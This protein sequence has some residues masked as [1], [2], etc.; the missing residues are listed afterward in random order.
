M[1]LL[2]GGTGFI[3]SHLL[4]ELLQAG[5]EVVAV[6]RPGSTPVIPLQ[7]QPIWL[8]RSLLQ[9]TANDLLQV[10]VVIHLASAGVSPKQ[11]CWQVLEQIN[12]AAGL[13]LIQLAHQGGVRRFV[14]AGTCFEY[15]PEADAWDRIP[16]GAHLRPTTPYGASKAAGFL[17]LHAFATAHSI[18]LFYG[19]IFSAYGEGQF[20]GNLWPSL[21]HAALAGNDFPMTE[22]EQIRDFIPVEAVSRHLRIATERSDLQPYQ[23]LVV[24]IGSGQGQ[25]VLDFAR[26]QWQ[27]MGATGS[28]N[29]G[30][31]PSRPGQLARLVADPIHLDPTTNWVY[32]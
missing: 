19:R 32:S 4:G 9:L 28:L 6:R 20:G 5:H 26:Q 30:A 22:G 25:R 13:H 21:R 24:N 11:A 2:T 1:I 3:G 16:P 15:G 29:P 14:A 27:L 18:K 23:P 17:M 10:E 7:Q 8:E 31:I 12:V